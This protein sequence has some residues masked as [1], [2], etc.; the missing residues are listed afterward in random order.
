MNK[1]YL[2]AIVILVLTSCKKGEQ[3]PIDNG[4]ISQVGKKHFNVSS[5][6]S[7][8]AVKLLQQNNL[9]YS[10]LSFERVILD[11]TIK[12]TLGSY[13]Y[14]HIFVM[15]NFNGLSLLSNDIGYHFRDGVLFSSS[16][17]VYSSIN[18]DNRPSLSLPRLRK[19]YLTEVGQDGYF[20]LSA[21]FKD[22][23]LVAELGYYDLNAGI[24]NSSPHFVKVWSVTPKGL[25]Y[26]LG[27]FRDDN[28]QTIS[29]FDGIET[30]SQSP[31]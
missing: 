1:I 7:L 12:N 29:Y 23:C 22:S 2:I 20:K 4:C 27:I 17:T 18:L 11:D 16:G 25:S 8:T 28:A 19:L 5:A 24:S 9:P 14:Q 26:P 15:Q 30:F 10:N 13:I 6:D 21:N 3:L 31:R